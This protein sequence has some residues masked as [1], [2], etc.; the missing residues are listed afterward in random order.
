MIPML[1]EARYSKHHYALRVLSGVHGVVSTI[2][3]VGE[4]IPTSL[5]L[6]I[7]QTKIQLSKAFG[8]P[9]N[10]DLMLLRMILEE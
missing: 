7:N 2:S 4:I 1:C 6:K 10:H 5:A 8:H 9:Q 3:R